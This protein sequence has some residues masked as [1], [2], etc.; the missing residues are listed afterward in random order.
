MP[1]RAL[2]AHDGVHVVP[3]PR[4]DDRDADARGHLVRAAERLAARV[5]RGGDARDRPHAAALGGRVAGVH[6]RGQERA[7]DDERRERERSEGE[8]EGDAE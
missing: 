2:R 7:V 5:V 8:V 4:R 1:R 6:V 3:L